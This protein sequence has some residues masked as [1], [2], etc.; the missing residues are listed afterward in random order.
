MP[1]GQSLVQNETVDR[2]HGQP[3][4]EKDEGLAEH[5]V[6][7]TNTYHR[8]GMRTEGGSV[9]RWGGESVFLC[10]YHQAHMT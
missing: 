9:T 5:D 2:W 1:V 4:Q 3:H 6:L 7:C 10:M 8:I